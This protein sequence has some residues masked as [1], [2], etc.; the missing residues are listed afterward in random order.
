MKVL[1]TGCAG[2]IGFH[3]SKK[4]INEGIS[5][6]GID[7]INSYYD[8]KL[9]KDRLKILKKTKLNKKY[10][11]L[12]HKIDISNKSSLKKIF[13]KY[14]FDQ[15]IHLAA[16]AGVR[17]SIEKPEAYV[18]SNLV[19]F[20]NILENCRQ[21]KIKHLFFA[22]TSS[23]YG[24]SNKFPYKETHNTDSPIQFYAAT[25][26]SNEVM[27]HSYS[28]LFNLHTTALR[29]F[30]VYG[31]WGRPDMALYKFTKN[32]IENKKVPLFNRGNHYR[33][34]TY[35]DD[36]IEAIILLVRKKRKKNYLD[37]KTPFEIINIGNNKSES[38]KKYLKII[39]K[40]LN[41]K[42]K[43]KLLPIQSGDIKTTLADIKVLRKKTNFK[44]KVSIEEG[45]S[46]FINWFLS[47]HRIN[48]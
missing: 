1:V 34:F 45:I 28:Y 21:K 9:K 37:K 10:K 48:K 26:K 7:N 31:P 35:I 27:A 12:F 16:Q 3:L 29:F 36:V 44:P 5:V 17:Y 46:K 20:A 6:V 4:L 15:V 14:N 38:L 42:S 30:T 18:N 32:I 41:K 8:V 2:F 25:K 13:K 19:G 40:K 22:S 11:F 47:Y 23:V 39:E 43:K 33:S 24:E